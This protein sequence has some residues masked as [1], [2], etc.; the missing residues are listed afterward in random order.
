MKS[1]FET[2]SIQ[3]MRL[4]NRFVRSATWE[5]M[6]TEDGHV[7]QQLIDLMFNLA[8]NEVGLIITGHA[9]VLPEGQ[10]GPWQLG[11]YNDEL[12]SGL[13]DMTKAVHQ[14]NGKIVMQIAHAGCH[15]DPE[16]T[17]QQP[18]GPSSLEKVNG[19]KCQEMTQDDIQR[20]VQAFGQAAARAR[21]SGFDGVQIH[22]AHGYFLSQFLSP[23]Y[24]HRQDAYGGS[25][26]NRSRIVREVYKIVRQNVGDTFPVLIKM[27]SE[28]FLVHGLCVDD[29][30]YVASMLESEGIDAIELSGGTSFSGDYTP[31]RKGKLE[32]QDK[33]VYYREAAKRYKS[34]LS[35]P[36]I[37][38]GGIRSFSVAK[39]L[40]EQ[41]QADFISLCR[42][43][44]REPDLIKRWKEGDLRPAECV[45]DN[46][47][48]VPARKGQGIYCLTRERED[49][50]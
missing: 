43:L 49:K 29:M 33:E 36:L 48:F 28:D 11:V 7:T 9:Y 46:L 22:A 30:L 26:E 42:P 47:C 34:R 14:V 37:L 2:V 25:L 35:L 12:I 4:A 18:L 15:A 8:Q 23:F 3:S 45:S 6:A 39:E 40:V 5:G 20:A 17:K 44:I 41:G 38:V 27:N 13:K 31:I 10:A 16:L 32:S 19:L 1:L 24:N 21:E 50:K